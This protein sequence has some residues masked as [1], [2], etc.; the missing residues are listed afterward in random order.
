MQTHMW[1]QMR[2]QAA[3]FPGTRKRAGAVQTSQATLV[4]QLTLRPPLKNSGAAGQDQGGTLTLIRIL[5][6]C[7]WPVPAG[8][9]LCGV[10][11][12]LTHPQG[13]SRQL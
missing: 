3:L 2:G 5:S 1:T 12:C 11:R 4:A 13:A 7:R 6:R 8:P 9:G 10:G